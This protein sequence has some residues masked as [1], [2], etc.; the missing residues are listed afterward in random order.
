[1][2]NFYT[3]VFTSPEG[4]PYSAGAVLSLLPRATA[5]GDATV[6]IQLFL[7]AWADVPLEPIL[8]VGFGEYAG[9]AFELAGSLPGP[10]LWG[11]TRHAHNLFCNCWP[12]PG[13]G[14]L[15]LR[16]GS[17]GFMVLRMPWRALTSERLAG[18][19]G[20][21]NHGLHS[22]VEFPPVGTPTSSAA[23]AC[24]SDWHAAFRPST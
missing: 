15:P 13:Y 12:R 14:G 23:F 11:S 21:C 16:G 2:L 9:R 22:M 19:S 5:T 20:S 10:S 7:Y 8:G 1:V 18:P 17:A 24:L 4:R 3:D 6:R